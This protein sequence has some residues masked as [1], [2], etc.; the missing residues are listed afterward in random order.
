[1]KAARQLW[2]FSPPKLLVKRLRAEFFRTLSAAPGVSLMCG[3]TEG[4]LYV[5]KAK[6]LRHR[7][8]SYRVATSERL[9][10]RILRLLPRVTRIEYDVC[11]DKAAAQGREA[12]LIC[13]LAPRFNRAGKVW[14]RR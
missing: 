5:G 11:P 13:V 8:G 1:M 3:P 6:N 14:A 12:L 2:W 9:P 10:R 7:L 4:V